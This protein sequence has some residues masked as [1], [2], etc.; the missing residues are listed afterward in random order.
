MQAFNPDGFFISNGP[1]DP[2]P[3][4]NLRSK[5]HIENNHPLFGICWASSDCDR[6][7]Y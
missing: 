1:G 2:E 5:R 7:W 6:K 4:E 3:L